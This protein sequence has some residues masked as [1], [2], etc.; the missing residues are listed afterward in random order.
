MFLKIKIYLKEEL[1][2]VRAIK[3]L[4]VI[5]IIIEIKKFNHLKNHNNRFKIIN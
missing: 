5:I 1:F 4:L 2:I 3:I